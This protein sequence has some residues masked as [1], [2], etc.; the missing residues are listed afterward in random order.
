MQEALDLPFD[1][2][3]MMMIHTGWTKSRYT[4]MNY[5]MYT[6]F[7]PILYITILN[8]VTL[9]PTCFGISVPSSVSCDIAFAKVMKY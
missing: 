4:V 2:L 6:Y 7:W 3:L 1:R 8:Y 9:A 5:I